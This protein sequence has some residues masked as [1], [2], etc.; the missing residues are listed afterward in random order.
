MGKK[1]NRRKRLPVS[2]AERRLRSIENVV[3]DKSSDREALL[4]AYEDLLQM[5]TRYVLPPNYFALRIAAANALGKERAE[6]LRAAE[7][8]AEHHPDDAV[9]RYNGGQAYLNQGY[10]LLALVE[11][12]SCLARLHRREREHIDE[13]ELRRLITNI[14]SEIPQAVAPLG[15]TWPDDRDVAL[16]GERVRRLLERGDYEASARK[17]TEVLDSQPGQTAVRNNLARSLWERGS[18]KEAVNEQRRALD[19]EPDRPAGLANMVRFCTLTGRYDEAERWAKHAQTLTATSPADLVAF[20]E[21]AAFRE[22]DSRVLSLSKSLEL[23]DDGR[24]A[25]LDRAASLLAGTACA[26]TGD[27]SGARRWWRYARNNGTSEEAAL[28]MDELSRPE[29]DRNEPW[30]FSLRELL[31]SRFADTLHDLQA[32]QEDDVDPDAWSSTLLERHPEL[33]DWVPYL[34]NQGDDLGRFIA[35]SILRHLGTEKPLRTVL[36][37]IQESRIRQ[38]RKTQAFRLLEIHGNI[39]VPASR[40]GASGRDAEGPQ[41]ITVRGYDISFEPT[42]EPPQE[43]RDLAEEGYHLLQEDRPEEAER[44]FLKALK[45]RDDYPS[46]LQNLAAAYERQGKQR[47]ARELMERTH[48]RF[49][50]Y[51]FGRYAEAIRLSGTKGGAG[52]ALQLLQP[53]VERK[54][55]H[56][57]EFT[58]LCHAMCYILIEKKELQ[59]AAG[60]LEMWKRVDPQDERLEQFAPLE[61]YAAL[62][63]LVSNSRKRRGDKK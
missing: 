43:I 14:A 18:L 37:L 51:A 3:I 7:A 27:T 50:D 35:L 2:M 56:V 8:G 39:E 4:A 49:P 58:G 59:G 63:N 25:I 21:I 6:I 26:R 10:L 48:R 61:G 47:E 16:A 11:F 13:D 17:A 33:K 40:L 23:R 29:D 45:I 60:W 38:E 20:M 53:I 12:E 62:R 22:D 31:P 41:T 54:K 9:S 57:T 42:E 24:S 44:L 32:S 15:L 1:K 34:L 30:Y 36:K 28:R 52:K 19:Q 5:E 46:L 55:F